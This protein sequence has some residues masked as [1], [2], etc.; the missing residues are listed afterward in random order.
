MVHDEEFMNVYT[1]EILTGTQAIHRFY[2]EEKHS[3]LE[4]WTDEWKPTGDEAEETLEMP[5]FTNVF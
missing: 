2:A 3:G 5:D 4:S 1:G